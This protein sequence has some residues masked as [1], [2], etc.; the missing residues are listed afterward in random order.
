MLF[1]IFILGSCIEEMVWSSSGDQQISVR[2]YFVNKLLTRV[3][4]C[5]MCWFCSF[6]RSYLKRQKQGPNQESSVSSSSRCFLLSPPL[7]PLTTVLPLLPPVQDVITS[8]STNVISKGHNVK[9]TIKW[10]SVPSLA[11]RITIRNWHWKASL[12]Q[13]AFPLVLPVHLCSTANSINPA[14]QSRRLRR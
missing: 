13:P 10:H 7:L 4:K 1:L 8:V 5:Q 3:S 11:T 9:L 14:L 2:Y 12:T 6:I